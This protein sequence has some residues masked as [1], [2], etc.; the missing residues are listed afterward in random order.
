MNSEPVILFII[1]LS[2]IGGMVAFSFSLDWYGPLVEV[3]DENA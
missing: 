3:K 2:F 1:I